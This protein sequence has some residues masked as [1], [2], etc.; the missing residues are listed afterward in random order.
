MKTIIK[1]VLF[2]VL[3]VIF[4]SCNKDENTSL[5]EIINV[6]IANTE[7]YKYDL[8][9]SGDEESAIIKTQAKNFEKSELIRDSITNWSIVYEYKALSNFKGTDFVE[10]ETCTGGQGIACSNIEI[11]RINFT[12]NN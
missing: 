12:I 9:I 4:E 3:I 11:V 1:L 7:N 10:I 8:F 6:T 2:I 5:A